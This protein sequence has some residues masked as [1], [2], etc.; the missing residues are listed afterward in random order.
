MEIETLNSGKA[1]IELLRKTQTPTHSLSL[2]TDLPMK[3]AKFIY[4]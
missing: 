3:M 1:G 4:W 2:I